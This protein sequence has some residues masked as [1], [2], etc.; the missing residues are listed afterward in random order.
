MINKEAGNNGHLAVICLNNQ[1]LILPFEILKK[2][3][4]SHVLF[5]CTIKHKKRVFFLS[6]LA[7]VKEI[8]PYHSEM[9]S[10]LNDSTSA[11]Y[12]LRSG[13][14]QIKFLLRLSV[15]YL[16]TN[17]YYVRNLIDVGRQSGIAN[18]IE[19]VPASRGLLPRRQL[20]VCK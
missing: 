3:L 7:G 11:N 9:M 2:T 12:T 19:E 14:F 18:S 10:Q 17:W 6:C 5:T 4:C 16:S 8:K 1:R 15:D 13:F 20:D